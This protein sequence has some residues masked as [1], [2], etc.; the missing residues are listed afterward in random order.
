MKRKATQSEFK[1]PLKRIPNTQLKLN[2]VFSPSEDHNTCP[3][4]TVASSSVKSGEQSWVSMNDH[5]SPSISLAHPLLA[6]RSYCIFTLVECLQPTDRRDFLLLCMQASCF[7]AP[8]LMDGCANRWIEIKR[9]NL[10]KYVLF[11]PHTHRNNNQQ[12][13]HKQL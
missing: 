6:G 8:E 2:A 4:T 11:S 13:T 5:P 9:F 12:H 1:Y 7:T 3:L 10:S